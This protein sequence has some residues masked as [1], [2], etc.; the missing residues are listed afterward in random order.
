MLTRLPDRGEVIKTAPTTPNEG[1]SRSRPPSSLSPLLPHPR[2][3]MSAPLGR[4]TTHDSTDLDEKLKITHVEHF[5]DGS[6]P[7]LGARKSPLDNLTI[8]QAV[9]VYWKASAFCF[10]AGEA[11]ALDTRV[12]GW[13]LILR[14]LQASRRCVMGTR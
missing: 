3:S 11:S 2:P 13:R 7:P 14:A 5:D 10:L 1:L 9:R 12:I 8:A 4:Q 6:S